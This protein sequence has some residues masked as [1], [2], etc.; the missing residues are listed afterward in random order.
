MDMTVVAMT[1]FNDTTYAN[2]QFGMYTKS[3]I[4]ACFTN[5]KVSCL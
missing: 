1:N 4:S 3:Q 2:G 5:F